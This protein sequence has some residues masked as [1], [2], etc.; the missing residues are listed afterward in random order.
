MTLKKNLFTCRWIANIWLCVITI[1]LLTAISCEHNEYPYILAQADHLIDQDPDS[2]LRMLR[3]I[4]GRMSHGPKSTEMYWRLLLTK[5]SDKSSKPMFTP[6][7]YE[8]IVRY[9]SGPGDKNLLPEALYYAGRV[10][11]SHNDALEARNYFLQAI[12]EIDKSDTPEDFNRLKGK[13]LSQIGSVYLYQDLC[14]ESVRMYQKAFEINH[15]SNDTVGMIF[16]LRDVA[17][18]YLSMSK[19]DS[20]LIFSNR[21]IM[22][23]SKTRDTLFLN[24]LFLLRSAAEIERGDYRKAQNDFDKAVELVPREM[25][26]AQSTIGARLSYVTGDTAECSRAARRMLKYGNLHD[27]R[28]ASRILAEL[29]LRNGNPVESMKLIKQYILLD[30]SVT[31]ID[32][33]ATILKINAL[34]DYSRKESENTVLKVQNSRLSWFL[35]TSVL[36]IVSLSV[37]GT[38]YFRYKRQQHALMKLKIEKLETLQKEYNAKNPII[39]QREIASIEASDIY[40]SIRRQI[41]S[42]EGPQHLDVEQWKEV[43]KAIE[44][45][46]PNFKNR[47]VSLC[48]MNDNE[49]KVCLLIKMGFT[50]TVIAAL[51]CHSKESVSATRRRLFEKAFGQ[52]RTPGEWDEFI[53]SL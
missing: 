3:A 51:T 2:A 13:C 19:P 36:L 20:S 45:I 12:E 25:S 27:R 29:M 49:I 5:A 53:R 41:N 39:I 34:Y 21:G 1:V 18:A 46:Y 8:T 47:L 52:K 22:L 37:L 40:K 38:L 48:K 44:T 42:P 33:A 26:I 6:T 16:N 4:E 31:K 7:E 23:A 9:Y 24:E 50:P 15:D 14:G 35:W 11:R 10:N 28:W 32:R 30:D 43:S 17:N